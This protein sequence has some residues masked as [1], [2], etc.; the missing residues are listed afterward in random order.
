MQNAKLYGEA[1]HAL[2]S[3]D[4]VSD[5]ILTELKEIAALFSEQPDYV[6]ILDSHKIPRAE[7]IKIIDE[8]FGGKI[9]EYTLNFIKLLSEKHLVH[10][11]SECTREFERLYN[12]ANNVTVVNVTTAK[13]LSDMLLNKLKEKMEAKTGGKI[14]IKTATDPKCIGGIIIKTDDM[15]IDASIKS[16]LEDMRQ[17]IAN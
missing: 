12:A 1:R 3:D 14:I 6:K 5:V 2:A 10:R 8:D 17:R 7:L 15:S 16:E 13:P 11:I 9:N 4:N